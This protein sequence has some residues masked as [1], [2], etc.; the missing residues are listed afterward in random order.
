M[1]PIIIDMKDM[2]DSREVYESRPHLIFA[3]VIYLVFAMLILGVV[4]AS[5]FKIDIVVTGMGTIA[6]RE[7]SPTITNTKAGVVTACYV[8]DGQA[9]EK[10]DI[11]YE[12]SCEELELERANYER[13]EVEN[14]KRLEM[15]EGYLN[16]LSNEDVDLTY[17]ADN[18]YYAEYIARSKLVDLNIE[19][20]EQEYNSEKKVMKQNF[21]RE[22]LLL[23]IM[24]EKF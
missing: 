1:K 8:E 12:V 10:G 17:Y 3:G 15:L 5:N 11:L 6:I 9:V 23:L 16:W 18:P 7:D 2:S 21:K 14:S 4:W 20:V 24:K 19:F 13:Q 22:Q